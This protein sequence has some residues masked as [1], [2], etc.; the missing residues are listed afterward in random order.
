M[1]FDRQETPTAYIMASIV[2]VLV[3]LS[4]LAITGVLYANMERHYKTITDRIDTMQQG[5]TTFHVWNFEKNK[6]DI[7]I[8][9]GINNTSALSDSPIVPIYVT[10]SF[11]EKG[12]DKIRQRNIK[13]LESNKAVEKPNAQN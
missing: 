9:A 1:S 4:L 2:T 7:Y 12:I 6:M 5:V 13:L 11:F 3:A 10:Q 8:A